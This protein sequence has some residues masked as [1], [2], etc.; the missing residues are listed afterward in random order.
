MANIAG[1]QIDDRAIVDVGLTKIYGIGLTTSKNLL[2][3]ANIDLQRRIGSLSDT[4]ITD[5]RTAIDKSEVLLEGELRRQVYLN[6]RRLIDIK[7][8][9]GL[10][11]RKKLPV[12]GQRTKTNARQKRGR[13]HAIAG[14]KKVTRH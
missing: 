7:S 2:K 1:I 13:S 8:Y 14:K 5:I 12:R 3:S 9:R 10:R 4:E 11:H 6:T